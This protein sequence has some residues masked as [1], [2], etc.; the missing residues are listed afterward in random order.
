MCSDPNSPD[1][2]AFCCMR[3]FAI[4]TL[5]FGAFNVI[6]ALNNIS[7]LVFSGGETSGS[8]SGIKCEA[9]ESGARHDA[10]PPG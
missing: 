4:A 7:T 3:G 6:G 1:P 9:F 8:R 5:V 10:A 2:Q